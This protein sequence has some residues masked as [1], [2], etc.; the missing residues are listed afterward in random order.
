M[1][2]AL[3]QFIFSILE[4]ID[5]QLDFL[6]ANNNDNHITTLEAC[7]GNRTLASSYF[8]LSKMSKSI[9]K[10]DW[11]PLNRFGSSWS[12]Q[13]V[14]VHCSKNCITFIAVFWSEIYTFHL[15]FHTFSCYKGIHGVLLPKILINFRV[16]TSCQADVK[17][18]LFNF[19]KTITKYI[20]FAK[21]KK[22]N[23]PRVRASPKYVKCPKKHSVIKVSLESDLLFS[24]D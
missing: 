7:L 6:R 19:F 1:T 21:V 2:L 22:K 15:I 23:G 16:K 5:F 3:A 9:W 14:C 24:D 4:S 13:I 18:E 17:F 10:I 8:Y 11:M 12:A 20:W